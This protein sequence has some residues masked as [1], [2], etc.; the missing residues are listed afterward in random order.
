MFLCGRAWE[1]TIAAPVY[2]MVEPVRRKNFRTSILPLFDIVRIRSA[3]R[4]KRATPYITEG[5]ARPTSIGDSELDPPG[6]VPR[7]LRER[8]MKFGP[9]RRLRVPPPRDRFQHPLYGMWGTTSRRFP[10]VR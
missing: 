9:T 10:E 2:S 6:T 4:K 3:S 8:A 5:L 7:L 1:L